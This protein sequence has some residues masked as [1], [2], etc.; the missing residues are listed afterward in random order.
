M[1]LFDRFFRL[2]TEKEKKTVIFTFFAGLSIFI[3]NLIVFS[4]KEHFVIQ[5]T[6]INIIAVLV[7]LG[8]LIRYQYKQ[9]NTEKEIESNFSIFLTGISEGLKSNMTLPQAIK[10]SSKNNYGAL[11]PYVSQIVSQISWGFS[12]ERVLL[13]FAEKVKNPIIMRSVSTIIETYQSGGNIASSLSAV[14]NSVT[15]IEKIKRERASKISSQMLQGYIIYFIFLVVMIGI[16]NFLVP[17]LAS[18]SFDLFSAGSAPKAVPTDISAM[19]S[20]RFKHL[21]IIQGFFSGIIIG[22]LATG[23]ISSGLKHSVV[24]IVVG[25]AALTIS[26]AVL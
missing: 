19:Y 22:K 13:D 26:T 5:S 14:A 18:G 11:N 7:A 10:Y 4:G 15:E 16:Q 23:S 12:L 24:M 8:T 17:L 21:A 2:Y 9:Y 3:F 20:V 25:Y 6:V 1:E